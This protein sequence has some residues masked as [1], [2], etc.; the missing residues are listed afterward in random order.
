MINSI[1]KVIEQRKNELSSLLKKGDDLTPEIKHQVYGAINEIDIFL[2]TLNYYRD[3]EIEN[4]IKELKLVK[5]EK[6][7]NPLF[8]FF[9]NKKV[10][11]NEVKQNQP[12]KK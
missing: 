4:E 5:P 2:R 12:Q 11:E 1:T 8:G 7:Q 3:L 6:R 10:K 9:R